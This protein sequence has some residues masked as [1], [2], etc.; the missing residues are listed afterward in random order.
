[1]SKKNSVGLGAAVAGF[2][3]AAALVA[4]VYWAT[5][6]R[7]QGSPEDL[8]GGPEAIAERIKPVG[9]AVVAGSA[10]ATASAPAPAAPAGAAPAA[11][12]G[13]G[14]AGEAIYNRVCM[15]CHAT[16]AANA[17]KLGDKAAWEPRLGAGIDGLLQ[18]AINGKNAMPPRGTCADCSDADLKATIEFMI[19]KV[20]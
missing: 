4:V 1:M 20:Q 13:T 6:A 5:A 19:S 16:G 14:G 12:A 8:L 10:E 18:T 7:F 2:V 15:A 3:L 9:K 17:P 11:S